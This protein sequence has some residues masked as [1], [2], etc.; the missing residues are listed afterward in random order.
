LGGSVGNDGSL[1]NIHFDHPIPFLSSLSNQT[2]MA[3]RTQ[4][5]QDLKS[6]FPQFRTAMEGNYWK[7]RMSVDMFQSGYFQQTHWKLRFFMWTAALEALFTSHSSPQHRGSL[8]AKERV[9]HLLGATTLIYPAG[10]L[11]QYE[12]DPH[13]TVE[14]VIDEI[15]CLRNH[16]AH[17]DK[18]PDYYFQ[19][20]G[21]TGLNGPINKLETLSEAIS[22]IV[23]RSLLTI[24]KTNL[25][26]NFQDGAASESYFSSLGLTKSKLEQKAKVGGTVQFT[27]PS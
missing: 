5:V 4:D 17:G 21:R 7:F 27:C 9:K 14:N 12:P 22:S 18:V 26:V 19:T 3:I 6:V 13:L 20:T 2:V 11:S 8:V 1:N 16:I 24:L 25:L 15:Y 10:E 23:R